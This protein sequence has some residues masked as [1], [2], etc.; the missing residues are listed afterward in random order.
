MVQDED[1]LAV[2]PNTINRKEDH[3]RVRYA[4]FLNGPDAKRVETE[5][6]PQGAT[7]RDW[8]E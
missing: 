6:P 2:V 7:R 5:R 3:A 4:G 1:V 8:W